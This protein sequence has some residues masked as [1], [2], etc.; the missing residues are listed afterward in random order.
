MSKVLPGSS[1]AALS[2][3]TQNARA[4]L[5]VS[6]VPVVLQAII[7]Y[8][9]IR[10]IASFY[11]AMAGMFAD[12]QVDGRFFGNY[13]QFMGVISLGSIL[14]L[15]AMTW[16]FVMVIRCQAGGE[17]K[18]LQL[19]G[20]TVKATFLTMV[21]AIGMFFLVM[22]AYI[23]G[24]IAMMIVIAI[25]A[26]VAASSEAA[27][28]VMAVLVALSVTALL[29]FLAWLLCR[30]LVG[31]P[32]V[33]LGHSPDFFKDIWPLARGESWGVPLRMLVSTLI[34]YV[35]LVIV[36]LVV[37][38]STFV[39]FIQ[40]AAGD[41]QPEQMFP[42]LADL[43]EALIPAQIAGMVVMVPFTWFMSILL[44]EAFHRFRNRDKQAAATGP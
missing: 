26:A 34:F 22:A 28:A 23:V 12:G 37:G 39:N 41:L 31:L 42:L 3:I 33:A 29:L 24:L 43:L 15:L 4:L 25:L 10:A 35:P 40:A 7:G 6:I 19:D 14:S 2:F 16:L 5:T 30:F 27:G 21:Y 38:G 11:R 44:G 36:Y 17:A 8:F 13:F 18:V 9:Q 1:R 20:A 32:G